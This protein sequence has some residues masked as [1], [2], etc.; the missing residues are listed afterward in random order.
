M[1]NF[2]IW[3]YSVKSLINS[4]SDWKLIIVEERSFF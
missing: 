4:E 1:L 3:S 2:P